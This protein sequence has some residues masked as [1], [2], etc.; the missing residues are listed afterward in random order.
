MALLQPVG[1]KFLFMWLQ[2]F[3]EGN[4]TA[5][6]AGLLV[7]LSRYTG[8]TLRSFPYVRQCAPLFANRMVLHGF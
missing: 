4:W 5:G 8:G 7:L 6:K 1:G 2:G 3:S